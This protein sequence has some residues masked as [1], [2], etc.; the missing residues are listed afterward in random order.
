M[1]KYSLNADDYSGYE[2]YQTGER[3]RDQLTEGQLFTED[4]DEFLYYTLDF[5][6]FKAGSLK[7]D[8]PETILNGC[9]VVCKTFGWDK[10]ILAEQL[11]GFEPR[12]VDP[13]K[14]YL[15]ML[16]QLNQLPGIFL[17]ELK[18]IVHADLAQIDQRI[19]QYE[20]VAF[21]LQGAI[22][23]DH[24]QK[25]IKE[26]YDRCKE[27]QSKINDY[28]TDGIKSRALSKAL[29][30]T[31]YG[32]SMGF[33]EAFLDRPYKSIFGFAERLFDHTKID[34]V[35]HRIGEVLLNDARQL[36]A[37]YINDKP[38]FYAA[39][40]QQNAAGIILEQ[41]ISYGAFL[42]LIKVQR[43]EIFSE[44]KSLYLAG[45]W[46]GFYALA[47]TQIEGL[48]GD[49]VKLCVPNFNNP[50]ASLP[51]KVREVRPFY[52]Y[53][54]TGLD[55]FQFEVP[56][57]RNAFLHKGVTTRDIPTD[58]QAIETLCNDV[59]FDVAECLRIYGMLDVD[60]NWL[61][62]LL[63]DP[64]ITE[65]H[66]VGSFCFYFKLISGVKLK[67]QFVFF[68]ERINE[69]N[70]SVFPDLVFNIAFEINEV[71]SHAWDPVESF[72]NARLKHSDPSF[73]LSEVTGNEINTHLQDLLG[74]KDD[75]KFQHEEQVK[76]LL[77]IKKFVSSYK[78]VFSE[79]H[80]SEDTKMRFRDFET[81]VNLKKLKN[82]SQVANVIGFSN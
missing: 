45:S 80:F 18:A 13:V 17:A 50:K 49:M 23:R 65:F 35:G 63:K 19:S 26:F 10:D 56:N 15:K 28:L 82:I 70:R 76:T 44:L 60:A 57:Q 29:G 32:S 68:E 30:E 72:I 14:Q 5:F 40:F 6:D 58:N 7:I 47:L 53:S 39:V 67:K 36:K 21:I 62:R 34:R 59:L 81:A 79:E 31:P 75:L 51:D 41:I 38:G 55:Y 54:E 73:K 4:Q 61:N 2:L 78:S 48:F 22:P 37:Q 20:T 8:Q 74:I 1:D 12:P 46:Y 77:E 27:E 52:K 24:H 43:Q 25:T 33:M 66:S 71:F 42:P 9:E 64:D 16:L 3:I 11:D 69:L